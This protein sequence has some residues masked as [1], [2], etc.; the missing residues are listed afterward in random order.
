MEG[1]GRPRRETEDKAMKTKA[2]T[3]LA[4]IAVVLALLATG[5][6]S[7]SS[8]FLAGNSCQEKNSLEGGFHRGPASVSAETGRGYADFCHEEVAD[9]VVAPKAGA[10]I[11]PFKA[12][13]KLD[14]TGAS[15]GFTKQAYGRGGCRSVPPAPSTTLPPRICHRV[16]LF[17]FRLQVSRSVVPQRR[18]TAP[19]SACNSGLSC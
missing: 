6:A 18:P 3:W 1:I 12:G 15:V 7:A 5:S 17:Y 8:G 19:A 4:Q 11:T 14:L 16:S 13:T 2:T 9:S 10:S